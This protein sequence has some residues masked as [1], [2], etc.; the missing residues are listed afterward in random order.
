MGT[1]KNGKNIPFL[2]GFMVCPYPTSA[3]PTNW[4]K[5]TKKK[6]KTRNEEDL[7]KLK[8]QSNVLWLNYVRIIC[9]L[10]CAAEGLEYIKW[11]HGVLGLCGVLSAAEGIYSGWPTK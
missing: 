5:I 6:A 11:N 1:W 10:I 2:V 4:F 3:T 8:K 9:D 7:E